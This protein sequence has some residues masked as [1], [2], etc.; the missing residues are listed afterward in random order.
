MVERAKTVEKARK[1][2]P[3]LFGAPISGVTES[4][5]KALQ[6]SNDNFPLEENTSQVGITRALKILL[7]QF[8]LNP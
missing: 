4:N 7:L 3:E 8:D 1:R 6:A 5:G 2:V